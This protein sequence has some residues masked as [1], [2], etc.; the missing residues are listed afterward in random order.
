MINSNINYLLGLRL[1]GENIVEYILDGFVDCFVG[2]GS[3]QLQKVHNPSL[4]VHELPCRPSWNRIFPVIENEYGAGKGLASSP[5]P[6]LR[7]RRAWYTPTAHVQ[8]YQ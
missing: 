8:D 1:G 6:S 3:I 4:L 2:H 7:R 5:G